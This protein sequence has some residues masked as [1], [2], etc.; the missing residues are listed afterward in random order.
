MPA[1]FIYSN[2]KVNPFLLGDRPLP[3]FELVAWDSWT[4]GTLWDI[5]EE[6]GYSIIGKTK[7]HGQLWRLEDN[8]NEELIK[9]CSGIFSGLNREINVEVVVPIDELVSENL[10][11]TT[12]ALQEINT[13]YKIVSDGRWKF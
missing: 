4:L 5:G 3:G 13:C 10:M 11:A 6:A 9:Q 2:L 12:Y 7:V 8:S 1:Y